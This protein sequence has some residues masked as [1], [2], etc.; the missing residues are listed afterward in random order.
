MPHLTLDCTIDLVASIDS[1]NEILK[2][3]FRTDLR[4][5]HVLTE[6]YHGVQETKLETIEHY[7][8]N[9]RTLPLRELLNIFN[10]RS[11]PLYEKRELYFLDIVRMYCTNIFYVPDSIKVLLKF[12]S[13][14]LNSC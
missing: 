5:Y 6:R 14:P 7:L 2:M 9:Y 1:E 13:R 3:P 11:P 4:Q 8:R 10:K 12:V